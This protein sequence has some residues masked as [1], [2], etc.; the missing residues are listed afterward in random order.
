M[1]GDKDFRQNSKVLIQSSNEVFVYKTIIPTFAKYADIAAGVDSNSWVAKVFFADCSIYLTLGAEKETILALEDLNSIGYRLSSARLDLDSDHLRLMAKKI[2]TYHAVSFAM[3]IRND[4]TLTK[5]SAGLIPFH[6][7]SETQGDLMSYK[8]LCPLSFK[9]FFNYVSSTSK[10]RTDEAFLMNISNLRPRVE[11]DFL[12]IMEDF[13]KTDHDFAAVLHGDYYRNNVMFKYENDIPI[14]L[15][16][17]DFQEVRYAS[18]AI[19]LS[20][21]MFMHVNAKL[22]PLLW[23]EL[24]LL[25]HETLIVSLVDILKCEK[26]DERLERFSFHKFI[27][28]FKKFAFYGVAVSILSIPWMASPE[29]DTKKISDFF[30]TDMMNAE[31]HALLEVCGGEDVNERMVDNV[32]HA[33]DKGYMDIFQ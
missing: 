5:L 11:N 3:K 1:K 4:P 31:F 32:K 10:H 22:K 33:S 16:M 20:I 25:Y 13:L 23:D 7:K 17:F 26:D 24:L 27:E 12:S 18:I 19:D 30:E 28:H 9:R 15:R 21:F 8:H 6:Y 2:A 14:D 29:D